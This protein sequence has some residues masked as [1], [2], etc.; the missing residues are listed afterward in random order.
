MN[1]SVFYWGVLINC[2]LKLTVQLVIEAVGY[3]ETTKY[4]YVL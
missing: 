4:I 3:L 1:I 2:L